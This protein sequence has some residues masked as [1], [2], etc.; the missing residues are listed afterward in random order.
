VGNISYSFY[1]MHALTLEVIWGI[2]YLVFRPRP[3]SGVFW[4][5]LAPSLAGALLASAALFTFFEKRYSLASPL[6]GSNRK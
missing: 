3:V 2:V 4:L 1:L 6:N 5:G